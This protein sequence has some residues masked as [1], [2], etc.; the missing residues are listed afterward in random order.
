M[1]IGSGRLAPRVPFLLIDHERWRQSCGQRVRGI[2]DSYRGFRKVRNIRLKPD[3]AQE[4]R[5]PGIHGVSVE[6]A[7]QARMV[8]ANPSSFALSDV[9]FERL[10]RIGS[11]MIG[12]VVQLDEELVLRQSM[13]VEAL[14]P[15]DI[16]DGKTVLDGPT[17]KVLFRDIDKRLMVPRRSFGQSYHAELGRRRR[18][19][20]R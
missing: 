13:L 17:V 6:L 9:V 12:R 5:E 4:R 3:A 19:T 7:Q 20:R 18:E 10:L 16:V 14:G 15:G 1:D 2:F 11:P 8:E